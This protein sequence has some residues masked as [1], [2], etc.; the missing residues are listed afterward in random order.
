MGRSTNT[1]DQPWFPF[2][3]GDSYLDRTCWPLNCLI[4]IIPFLLFYQIGSVIQPLAEEQRTPIHV[5]AFVLMLRFFSVFG[6]VGSYLPVLTVL[7]LLLGWHFAEQKRNKLYRWRWEP[8]IYLAMAGESILWAIPAFVIGLAALRQMAPAMTLGV[9]TVPVLD[10]PWTTAAVL[11][12]GAGIYEEL[13]FRLVLI[14]LL[15]WLL[16]DLFE[17]KNFY[18]IPVI[19]VGSALLFSAYH[20]LGDTALKPSHFFYLTAFGIYCAGVFIY[21]GFGIVVGAHAVYDLMI[22]AWYLYRGVL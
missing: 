6:A 12:V 13:L 11:S 21:R 14:A 18:A 19:V 2:G 22:V 20:A 15:D 10:L 7:L 3:K 8:K 4:F 5:M 16:R 9:T 17:W 1:S